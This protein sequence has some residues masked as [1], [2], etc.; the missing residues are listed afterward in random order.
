MVCRAWIAVLATAWVAIGCAAQ[1]EAPPWPPADLA[2]RLK[3]EPKTDIDKKIKAAI[4]DCEG[5]IAKLD[6]AQPAVRAALGR[7][8]DRLRP[9]Y[10]EY[11]R[12]K[13][14]YRRDF[15]PPAM[16]LSRFE[17]DIKYLLGALAAGK[18]PFS[19]SAGRWQTR[20][21]WVERV[22]VMGHFDLIVPAAYDPKKSWPLIISF[23]DDPD[24]KQLRKTPYFL[25]RCIQRGYPTGMTYVEN[26]T[27][28]Y[29]KDVARDYN[30]DPRRIY[31]TGFSYGGHTDLVI[32]WRYPHWFAAI[33]PVC[34][35]L[36][37]KTTP[38][39]KQLKNVPTLLLHG[40]NDS[41]LRTGKIIH[42]YM[43]EAGCP[44]TWRTYP[45]GHAPTLPFR[46]D[47][48]VLT[49]FFD[50]HVMDPNPKTVSHVIEHKRYSRA[51]WVNGKMTRDSGGMSAIFEVRV[52]KDNRIE[53][54]A[55]DQVASLEL[56]LNDK[57]VD[58]SKPVTVVS[59]GKTLYRGKAASPLKV[60]LR[61]GP[62]YDDGGGDRLWRDILEIK[63][64]AAYAKA[65]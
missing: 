47:V 23:Q 46:K 26:K 61:D 20:T 58:M 50:R 51:F 45:G 5:R 24:Y 54:D 13:K 65:K 64:T 44:V 30:I 37:D 48:T 42:K 59:A 53:I 4:A 11:N 1:A 28:T 9:L 14:R 32:A 40:Q 41:F 6:A 2:G 15:F 34:N 19:A 57:L 33:A 10:L 55:N 16:C 56:D 35:D 62:A 63:K 60:K 7:L 21:C 12:N 22:N 3:S 29:L 31:A 38:F 49:K 8:R 18:E 17:T 36:R 27:R 43:T 25:I 39:V 52:V